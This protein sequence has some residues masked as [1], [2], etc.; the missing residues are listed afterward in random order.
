M[1]SSTRPHCRKSAVGIAASPHLPATAANC[2]YIEFLPPELS[3]S[4]LRP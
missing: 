1:P 3:E 2:P 4:A